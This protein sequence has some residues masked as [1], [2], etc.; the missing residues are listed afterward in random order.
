LEESLGME[1]IRLENY[2]NEN[3]K[4]NIK[5]TKID[6]NFRE[7]N[8]KYEN[9]IQQRDDLLRIHQEWILNLEREMKEKTEEYEKEKR[10]IREQFDSEIIGL[11]GG[12]EKR[13]M[14]LIYQIRQQQ[15][16]SEDLVK[17]RAHL[18][19]VNER[20]RI[21]I[22]KLIR[23]KSDQEHSLKLLLAEMR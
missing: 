10:R 9:L 13:E 21:E 2:L 20:M 11:R 5:I 7:R 19:L 3:L 23:E 16:T 6:E 4:L 8:L 15:V 18:I 14:D 12:A 17:E 1:K 22:E